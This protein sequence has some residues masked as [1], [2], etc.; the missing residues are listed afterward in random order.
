MNTF[1]KQYQAIEQAARTLL[2]AA[3]K[4]QLSE[5]EYDRTHWSSVEGA[6][7]DF[8]LSGIDEEG[9][10]FSQEYNDAC[11]CHPEYQTAYVYIKWQDIEQVLGE[12]K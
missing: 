6:Q 12:L 8:R 7:S 9:I 3:A 11:G 1:L 5:R 4:T 2:P 10:Q